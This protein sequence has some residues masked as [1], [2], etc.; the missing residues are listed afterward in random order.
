MTMERLTTGQK[1]EKVPF[2]LKLSGQ[3]HGVVYDKPFSNLVAG[4]LGLAVLTG[5]VSNAPSAVAWLNEHCTIA[6]KQP[7]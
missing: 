5:Q 6:G 4:E 1:S 7:K 2:I 3:D